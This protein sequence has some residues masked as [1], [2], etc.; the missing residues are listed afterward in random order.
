MSWKGI[1][2]AINRA[3]AQ[4]L[5]TTGQVESTTDPAFDFNEKRLRALEHGLS[6]LEHHTRNY[7]N[8]L[9][10]VY[11]AHVNLGEALL[12]FYGRN[13]ADDL[14]TAGQKAPYYELA[15][16]YAVTLRGGTKQLHELEEPYYQTVVNPLMRFNGYYKE[17]DSA[18]KKRHRKLLDYDALRAKAKKLDQRTITEDEPAQKER[19]SE[20]K[21]THERVVEA[22]NIYNELNDSLKQQI[23]RLISHRAEYFDPSFEAFVKL[24]MRYFEDR[25]T[26]LRKLERLV[27]A[28]TRAD[29]ERGQLDGRMDVALEKMKQL[30]I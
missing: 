6:K 24:Q 2:K 29:Y 27:D 26:A 18:I 11:Q 23:P 15:Q 3:G 25:Y 17:I 22:E 20:V 5:V 16:E 14:E 12:L 7:L 28:G 4:V 21:A 1:K 13:P 30:M 10:V 19:E 9:D 8:Q